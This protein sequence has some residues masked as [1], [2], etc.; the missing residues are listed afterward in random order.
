MPA[1]LLFSEAENAHNDSANHCEGRY[2]TSSWYAHHVSSTTNLEGRPIHTR[3]ENCQ[4]HCYDG[5]T[6]PEVSILHLVP[7]FPRSLPVATLPSEFLP[8]LLSHDS[9]IFAR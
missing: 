1:C 9:N 8:L 7:P 4:P 2:H 6:T 5:Q 3:E